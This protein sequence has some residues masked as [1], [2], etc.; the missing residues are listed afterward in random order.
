MAR[1]LS[2]DAAEQACLTVS[3]LMGLKGLKAADPW[4]RLLAEVRALRLETE[5][6][7]NARSVVANSLINAVEA[8]RKR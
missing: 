4:T 2:Q 7:E 5:F 6:L 8:D 3:D 1:Q